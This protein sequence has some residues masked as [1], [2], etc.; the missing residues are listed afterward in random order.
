[1]TQQLTQQGPYPPKYGIIMSQNGIE[2][3]TMHRKRLLSKG[4]AEQVMQ[5]SPQT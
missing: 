4:S 1:M 2:V 5:N 3:N